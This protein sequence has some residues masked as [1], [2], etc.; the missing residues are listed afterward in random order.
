M[1]DVF[2]EYFL[3][4]TGKLYTA[5]SFFQVDTKSDELFYFYDLINQLHPRNEERIFASKKN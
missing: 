3:Y 1:S 5:E 4:S 2:I